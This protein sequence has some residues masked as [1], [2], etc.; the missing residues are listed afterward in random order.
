[1]K[2]LTCWIVFGVLFLLSTWSFAQS[3]IDT[4]YFKIVIDDYYGAHGSTRIC[5]VTN[6]SLKIVTNCDFVG[7]KEKVIYRQNL[8][9]KFSYRFLKFVLQLRID[10]LRYRYETRGFDGLVRLVTIQVDSKIYKEI[11][12]ERFNHPTIYNLVL[13]IN[14]LIMDEKF[15]FLK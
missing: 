12:F 3:S 4:T 8:D 9:N 7:C 14:N 2:T 15:R 13:G 5:I 1:M 6:D 11:L 10:T